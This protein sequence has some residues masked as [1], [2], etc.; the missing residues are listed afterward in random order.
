MSSVK[1]YSY[2]KVVFVFTFVG[3]WIGG[4]IFLYAMNVY[5]FFTNRTLDVLRLLI[6]LALSP[7][8][9]IAACFIIPPAFL[10][11]VIAVLL[12]LNRTVTSLL[13]ISMIGA[14]L[15]FLHATCGRVTFPVVSFAPTGVDS[16]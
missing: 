3:P 8:S 4:L 13:S 12:R 10:T 15:S 9:A 2:F 7:I 14:A 1:K 11:S 5:F 16:S 6:E